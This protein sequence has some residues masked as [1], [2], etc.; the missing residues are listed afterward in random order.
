[1]TKET[2]RALCEAVLIPKLKSL[3]KEDLQDIHATLDAMSGQLVRTERQLEA[4]GA[5]LEHAG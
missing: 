1:M 3:L 2:F 4:I 5:Q